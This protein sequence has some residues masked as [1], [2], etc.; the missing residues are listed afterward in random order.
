MVQRGLISCEI[1]DERFN[2]GMT[3]QTESENLASPAQLDQSA[4]LS[5]QGSVK[6]PVP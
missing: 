1:H 2:A 6:K 4:A 5:E 3:F